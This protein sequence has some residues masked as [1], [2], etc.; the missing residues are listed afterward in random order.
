MAARPRVGPQGDNGEQSSACLVDGHQ[1][2]FRPAQPGDVSPFVAD[3]VRPFRLSCTRCAHFL[4]MACE[5]G[6]ESLCTVCAERYRK[7]VQVVAREPAL[8]QRPGCLLFLTVTAPGEREHRKPGG[9][10]CRCTGADGVELARWNAGIGK[11]WNRFAQ[12]AQRLLERHG[13][14]RAAPFKCTEIQR[15]GALHVHSLWRLSSP[16]GQLAQLRRELRE[17]AID[18][19]FGHELD[20]RVPVEGQRS[21]RLLAW[22]C[23]KYVSKS[24]TER[25]SVPWHVEV[26]RHCSVDQGTGEVVQHRGDPWTYRAWSASQRW[27]LT[28]GKVVAAQRLW[29]VG[30]LSTTGILLAP[31][32]EQP[33]FVG[34]TSGQ[35]QL[36]RAGP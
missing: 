14:E 30:H 23:S 6:N 16:V 13:I 17:L 27:G 25:A 36:A 10:L 7:R 12:A 24:V 18:H 31:P 28:M 32:D 26:G 29:A 4:V 11:R 8:A 9:Q 34:V 20:V 21:T 15:R 33:P 22:Y 1:L 5:S 3:C 2:R 19:G 35:V